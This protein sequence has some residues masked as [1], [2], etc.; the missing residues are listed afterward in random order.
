MIKKTLFSLLTIVSLISTQAL[1]HAFPI[2]QG[3]GVHF[4]AMRTANL[5]LSAHLVDAPNTEKFQEQVR[6]EYEFAQSVSKAEQ[7]EEEFESAMNLLDRSM[8]VGFLVFDESGSARYLSDEAFLEVARDTS[9]YFDNRNQDNVGVVFQ[10]L[11]GKARKLTRLL[12]A[13]IEAQETPKAEEL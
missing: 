8:L 6:A 12:N 13:L 5:G 3:D 2:Y 4:I 10:A 7:T 9:P 11:E 1:G